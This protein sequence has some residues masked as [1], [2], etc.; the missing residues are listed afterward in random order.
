[1]DLFGNLME[2]LGAIKIHVLEVFF[3]TGGR[4]YEIKEDGFVIRI[5]ERLPDFTDIPT[6]VVSKK[7]K[8]EWVQTMCSI[9]KELIEDASFIEIVRR[10]IEREKERIN[11]LTEE[12]CQDK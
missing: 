8:G 7:Y 10:Q 2:K 5:F 4:N 9:Q 12:E 3:D 11:K 1:M 6:I